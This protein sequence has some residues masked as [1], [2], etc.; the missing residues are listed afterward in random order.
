[1]GR[2]KTLMIKNIAERLFREHGEEFTTDFDKNKELVKKYVDIPS[3][4]LRNTVA[5]YITRLKRR[6]IE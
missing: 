5:G 3:K 4:K 2:I 1:M 6:E